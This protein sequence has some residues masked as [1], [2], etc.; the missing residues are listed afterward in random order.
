MK[1]SLGKLLFSVGAACLLLSLP[2][3]VKQ[4]LQVNSD[5]EG[6]RVYFDGYYK[7]ETPVEFPFQWHGD[8]RLTLEK[9]GYR[10]VVEKVTLRAPAHMKMPMDFFMELAPVEVKDTHSYH[11]SL[12]PEE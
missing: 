7:G 5:P 11:R 2:G 10:P 6:A 4:R 8:H 12:Q 1:Q 3:C 9:D